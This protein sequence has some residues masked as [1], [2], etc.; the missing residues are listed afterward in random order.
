MEVISR[1]GTTAQ[2]DP[3]RFCQWL[4][5]TVKKRGVRVIQPARVTGIVEDAEGVLCGVRICQ[6]DGHGT[7]P[8][9]ECKHSTSA[10]NAS[11]MLTLANSTMYPPRSNLR[12]LVPPRLQHPLPLLS[13]PY[14]R[15]L[16]R[17][18]LP[19]LPE[20]PS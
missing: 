18:A 10:L 2:I 14:P 20:S 8:N 9:T 11:Q 7:D 16:A 5:Q 6:G 12:R 3:L 15:L 4:L 19:A 13:N 17:R 1:D